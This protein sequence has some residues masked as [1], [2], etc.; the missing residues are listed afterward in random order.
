[1]MQPQK[2]MLRKHCR[3]D[4]AE[5]EGQERGSEDDN[6]APTDDG[7]TDD[8]AADVQQLTA[9]EQRLI[10]QRQARDMRAQRGRLKGRHAHVCPPPSPN[11]AICL[12]NDCNGHPQT[13]NFG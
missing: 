9:I 4:S 10:A 6:A 1:M 3:L 7:G 2:A 12:L 8:D 13:C 11:G 5:S